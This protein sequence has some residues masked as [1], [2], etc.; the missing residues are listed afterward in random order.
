MASD[1]DLSNNIWPKLFRK[2]YKR[3]QALK[4]KKERDEDRNKIKIALAIFFPKFDG[5][6]T[7]L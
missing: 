1:I 3:T 6:H 5:E 4:V 7:H 2:R